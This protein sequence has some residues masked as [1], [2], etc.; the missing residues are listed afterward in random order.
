MKRPSFQFYP[1]DWRKDPGVQ[2]LPYHDR[3][4][5]FEIICL[6]HE[7]EERG[8]LLLNGRP[9]PDDALARLLG[10]DKQKL[11]Q[12]LSIL[13]EFGV[14][15]RCESTGALMNRRMVRDEAL[16]KIRAESGK[17]GGNPVLL[18]QNTKQKPTTRLNQKST[19]S[20]SSSSS[21][22]DKIPP[23]P[24][25]GDGQ[26]LFGETNIDHKDRYLPKDWRK[27][28]KAD[29]KKTKV[30]RNSLS[31]IQIGAWFDR[32]S[33]TLWTVAEAAALMMIRPTQSEIDGMGIYYQAQ[34]SADDDIRRR[35]LGTLLNN[36]SGELDRARKFVNSQAA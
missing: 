16:S 17:M 34:I 11:N 1:A 25:G 7:S 28:S 27:I 3:G 29:Q 24:Q 31:M 12:T 35:D 8:K 15:Q 13:M 2:A 30:L 4:V 32:K 14:A 20:S 19:P 5:W 33:E 9:M 36:W 18:N 26:E 22:S 23:N 6:L 10:L 21:S